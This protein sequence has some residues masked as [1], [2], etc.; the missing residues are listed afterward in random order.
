MLEVFAADVEELCLDFVEVE[1]I[2]SDTLE[3]WNTQCRRSRTGF[4]LASCVG[5]YLNI[6]V[7]FNVQKVFDRMYHGINI[8]FV[9]PSLWDKWVPNKLST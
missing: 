8:N 5:S 1:S 9:L 2:S 6:F 4:V 7:D 3:E